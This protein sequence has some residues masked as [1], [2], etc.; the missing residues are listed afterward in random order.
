MSA[1]TKPNETVTVNSENN[2][3]SVKVLVSEK[4]YHVELSREILEGN[5]VIQRAIKFETRKAIRE[6]TKS[7]LA[8]FSES[9]TKDEAGTLTVKSEYVAN[10]LPV[11]VAGEKTVKTDQFAWMTEPEKVVFKN[12]CRKVKPAVANYLFGEFPANK[13][14]E[15]AR[16]L[17]G[18]SISD[19]LWDAVTEKVSSDLKIETAPETAP[20]D[21]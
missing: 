15:T 1:I 13:A 18:A 11:K 17:Y 3:I 4:F 21:K 20:E 10:L 8:K 6:A 19:K 14:F 7:D 12:L 9:L 5:S 16:K 2:S